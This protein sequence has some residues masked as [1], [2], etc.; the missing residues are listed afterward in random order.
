M[1]PPH[2]ALQ[3]RLSSGPAHIHTSIFASRVPG[4]ADMV[5]SVNTEH[6]E[7]G[8]PQTAQRAQVSV[9]VRPVINTEHDGGMATPKG[10]SVSDNSNM[11]DRK[12]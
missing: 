1:R 11:C 9:I 7:G 3:S 5:P 10:S 12:W 2:A 6:C 4:G 8:H